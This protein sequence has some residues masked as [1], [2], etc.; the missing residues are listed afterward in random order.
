MERYNIVYTA[1]ELLNK[2]LPIIRTKDELV[3]RMA[4]EGYITRNCTFYAVL[5]SAIKMY[6]NIEQYYF[7]LSIPKKDG[8]SRCLNV[9]HRGL[10]Q[11]QQYIFKEILQSIKVSKVAMGYTKGKNG[12]MESA[13]PHIG[14]KYVIKLDIKDFFENISFLQIYKVF[15]E[16]CGY[17][18]WMSSFFAVMCCYKVT[19]TYEPTFYL[20]E[21]YTIYPQ[22]HVLPQGACTSPA[23]SNI[24]LKDFDEILLNYCEQNEITYTRYCDDLIFSCNNKESIG[25]IIEKSRRELNKFDFVLNTNKMSIQKNSDRQVVTGLVVNDKVSVPKMY[26][27]KIRQEIYF[28]KKHG[29]KDHL[30]HSGQIYYTH[31]YKYESYVKKT[32]LYA[33]KYAQQLLGRIGYVISVEPNNKEFIGYQ[34]YLSQILKK[35]D[36]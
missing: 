35:P 25:L 18:Q 21:H 24:I 36:L 2:G 3:F 8:S 27:K 32:K 6:K 5:M 30:K 12:I 20:T 10:K 9:P 26:C 7:K 28:I 34:E 23:L 22:K 4:K 31:I 11:F 14:K 33:N 13:L 15:R 1:Q 16:T 19:R 29:I 17:N